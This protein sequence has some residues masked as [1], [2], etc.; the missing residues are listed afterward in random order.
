MFNQTVCPPELWVHSHS[1]HKLKQGIKVLG[2]GRLE[3]C[4]NKK[5][6][7]VEG[8]V[9]VNIFAMLPW[10]AVEKAKARHTRASGLYSGIWQ[11]IERAG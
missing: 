4:G 10:E 2:E 11:G 6:G 7:K 5:D 8:G 1:G 9:K 3:R